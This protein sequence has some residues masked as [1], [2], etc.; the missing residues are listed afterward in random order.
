M[1]DCCIAKKLNRIM[2]ECRYT[3]TANGPAAWRCGGNLAQKFNRITI[4]QPCTS[5][6]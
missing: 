5:A 2:P 6:Q 1:L 4:A 3:M